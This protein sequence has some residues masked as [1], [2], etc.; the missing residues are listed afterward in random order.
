MNKQSALM[1]LLLACFLVLAVPASAQSKTDSSGEQ[2]PLVVKF[3]LLQM[4]DAQMRSI[5]DKDVFSREPSGK[6]LHTLEVLTISKT[7]SLLHL[8][9]KWPIIYYDPR[10]EQFQI[11]Y[12]DTGIK[13]D[14]SL[15][16]I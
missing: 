6:T 10:A 9:A 8:G 16:H 11:Q 2:I 15:I 1:A 14:L 12:V 7:P 3:K 13:L 4:S 5:L